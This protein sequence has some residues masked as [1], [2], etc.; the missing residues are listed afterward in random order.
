MSPGNGVGHGSELPWGLSRAASKGN[1]NRSKIVSSKNAHRTSPI[2]FAFGM[3]RKSF[4]LTSS[5]SYENSNDD[6][7]NDDDNS[8]NNDNG[9]DNNEDIDD[10]NKVALV[11]FDVS[12]LSSTGQSLKWT[13][14]KLS[15]Q[16]VC[17]LGHAALTRTD[18]LPTLEKSQNQV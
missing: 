15:A 12:K 9:V 2:A 5:S 18:L 11:A 6:V 16:K 4:F 10:N 3:L 13:F 14:S 8:S 7:D 17:F 1:Q